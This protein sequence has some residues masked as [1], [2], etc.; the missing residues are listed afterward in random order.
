MIRHKGIAIVDQPHTDEWVF[1]TA[2][3]ADGL[4]VYHDAQN[5]KS[6]TKFEAGE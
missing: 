4:H 5:K 1:V 2:V 6:V 3:F